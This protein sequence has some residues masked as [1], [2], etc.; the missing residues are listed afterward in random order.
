MPSANS[1]PTLSRAEFDH[2][3]HRGAAGTTVVLAEMDSAVADRWRGETPGG[4]VVTGPISTT[5]TV[6]CAC[7][8]ST[9]P[10]L[11]VRQP[12]DPPLFR[13]TVQIGA[14]PPLFISVGPAPFVIS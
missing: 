2:L 5:S 1:V 11:R 8:R 14:V 12:P 10:A 4:A 9:S 7:T 6:C 3:E 13:F